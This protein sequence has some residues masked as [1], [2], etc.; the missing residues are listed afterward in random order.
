[1]SYRAPV[2][3]MLFDMQYLAELDALAQL[4]GLAD[5]NSETAAAVLQECAR[6]AEGVL[7]PLNYSAD[8]APSR[9]E[10]GRVITSAG[11]QA[12]YEQ[13]RA[14]GWQGLQH[15]ADFGGQ[16]LPK[17]I[18]AACSEMFASA[19]LSFS[20][21]SLL[22]DG[23]TEALLTAGSDALKSRYLPQLISGQWAGT[24]NLTEPQ[25]GSDLA[26]IRS[27]AERQAD[28]SY[29][30][31]GTK[32]FI[33]Y[34]EQ[35]LSENIIHLVLART[36]DAPEGIKGISLFIVPKFLPAAD[37]SL[38]ARNDVH[39]VSIEHKLGITASPTC[40][41]QY[42]DQGGAVGYLVGQENL[43]LQY[44]FVM[45]N[46]ARY[47]VGLQG[48]GLA[49]RAYQH[50]VAYARERV[51]SRPVDGSAKQAVAI[52]AHP[53][54]R[55]MLMTMRALTQGCRALASFAAGQ[56]DRARHSPDAAER[57]R[58]QTLYEF[59]V[60]LVK[61]YSTEMVLEVAQLGVQ[62]H[63]GMGFIEETGAAQYLR[64]AKILAIYE[65]TTAIQAN[66]LLGRKTLRD[67][68]AFA[69][70]LAANIQATAEKLS[71]QTD[72]GAQS[73]GQHLQSAVA[74]FLLS[75]DYLCAHAQTQPNAVYAGSVPFLMLAGNLFAAW[76]MAQS[77]LA[78][79]ALSAGQAAFALQK[80]ITCV[81]YAEHLLPRCHAQAVAI[82]QGA[83]SCMAL[84]PEAF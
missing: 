84:A 29:R 24:M 8:Q 47:S 42:G 27:R 37:G 61:G 31:F 63:G 20:L 59:L 33:T 6:F 48:I 71:Q 7:A 40:V 10:D 3:D 34:G 46:A 23:A 73:M 69:R 38:G 64:D 51:Q 41:L 62:V 14:G 15:P 36:P 78:A 80:K 55:R 79:N 13:L 54:V 57:E 81:F 17:T 26:L 25:A 50:A 9:F 1:M 32:I 35:D 66:D 22:T 60:P 68:G 65:G 4:P 75:V 82:T 56:H 67:G 12:A 52:I 45:M 28:D 2:Q 5:A 70:S 74:D 49:E 83:G 72:A 39:C 44:M 19:N 16:G 43:G 11:F 77:W 76:Q 21:V 30:I 58:A 53:D 18:G